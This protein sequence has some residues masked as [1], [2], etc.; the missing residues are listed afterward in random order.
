MPG[1]AAAP[2]PVPV[3]QVHS[4][5]QREIVLDLVDRRMPLDLL[6]T[7]RKRHHHCCR[8]DERLVDIDG[9]RSMGSLGFQ[10]V[11]HEHVPSN[12]NREDKGERRQEDDDS[13]SMA[14]SR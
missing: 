3:G 6:G 1:F 10:V 13:A 2:G 11:E 5:P 12:A 7:S 4:A 8:I 14:L 9:R